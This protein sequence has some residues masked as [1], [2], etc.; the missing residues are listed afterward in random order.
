[1]GK[2]ALIKNAGKVAP[3]NEVVANTTMEIDRLKNVDPIQ[4]K[5]K[6]AELEATQIA[7]LKSIQKIQE[8]KEKAKPVTEKETT[9]SSGG[10]TSVLPAQSFVTKAK[11]NKLSSEY[12]IAKEGLETQYALKFAGAD[13]NQAENYRDYIAKMDSNVLPYLTSLIKDDKYA[14]TDVKKSI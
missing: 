2:S 11:A 9:K 5:D 3:L 8:A 6:I 7:A 4:N 14:G 1:M 10:F 12:F 13:E